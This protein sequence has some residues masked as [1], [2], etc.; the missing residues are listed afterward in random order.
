MDYVLEKVRNNS[1]R[2]NDLTI[3]RCTSWISEAAK[4]I[5]PSTIKKCF[6][7]TLNMEMFNSPD[8]IGIDPHHELELLQN[9]IQE[10]IGGES[11][12]TPLDVIDF[13][14]DNEFMADVDT[15]LE[16]EDDDEDVRIPDA[17]KLLE[18]TLSIKDLRIYL[19][20]TG[21]HQEEI[22]LN[23]IMEKNESHT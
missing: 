7:R 18:G 12:L 4:E 8:V 15:C 11:K 13:V 5:H 2:V 21:C 22:Y 10:Y 19:S 23:Y 16:H 14:M 1:F 17:K 20:N 9:K 3:A 6:F